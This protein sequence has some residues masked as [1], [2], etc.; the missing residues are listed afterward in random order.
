M[1][2]LVALLTIRQS[3]PDGRPWQ[4]TDA[5]RAAHKAWAVRT[6]GAAVWERYTGNW[7]N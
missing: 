6:Y 3:D 5:E 1:D 2:L 7:D 4:P